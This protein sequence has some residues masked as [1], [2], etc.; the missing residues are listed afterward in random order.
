[1]KQKKVAIQGIEGAFH[2]IA[3]VN[4][5][6]ALIDVIPCSSFAELVKT[7]ETQK[8]EYGMMAIENTVA[9]SI[10]PNYDLIRNSSVVI[11]GEEY[12]RIKQNLVGLPGQKIDDIK[13][14]HS[15]YMAISQCRNFFKAFPSIKLIESEDTALSAKEI[16]T[17]K[18][19][20][21]GGISSD[22]AAKK[23]GLEILAADIET[24]KINYTR[25]F[26]L[27][28]NANL[29]HEKNINKASLSFSV[30]HKKASLSSVLSVLAFYD[31]NLTKIESMPLMGK[32]FQYLF[33][34][35]V[36]FEN[37]EKF[38]QCIVA[39]SPLIYDFQLLGEYNYNIETLQKLH[40]L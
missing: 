8:A 11:V 18:L 1:M 6:G 3:A 10:L 30:P 2:E 29:N 25:F 28:S 13:E 39:I 38:K 33:Y 40:E 9:G 26:S 34:I 24:N 23:Y 21:F 22:L 36:T 32:A 7:V 17:K 19:T 20:N 16:A 35:D 5:Y 14:V 31:L 37:Y 4:H 12:L 27:A 15:H